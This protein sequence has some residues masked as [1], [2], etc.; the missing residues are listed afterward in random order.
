MNEH[1]YIG[2][3]SGTSMDGIDAV[4]VDFTGERTNLL[5]TFELPYPDPLL[6]DL[7]SIIDHPDRAGLVRIGE[8]HVRLGREFAA[9]ARR[10]IEQAGVQPETI[11]AI[12]SHGQTV[13]HSPASPAPF[14]IQLGDPGTIAALTGVRVVADTRECDYK[15]VIHV[16]FL[17]LL[18]KTLLFLHARGKCEFLNG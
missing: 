6:Q 3:M 8:L 9:A 1:L 18:K 10:L 16:E 12:G 7:N 11:A 14:S 13:F 4:L 2:L 15:I 17:L 5:E